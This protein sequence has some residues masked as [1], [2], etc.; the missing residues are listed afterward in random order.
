MIMPFGQE[1]VDTVYKRCVKPICDELDLE[2]RHAGELFGTTPIYN[3]ILREIQDATIIV[4]DIS[5][6]NPNVFYELGIAHTIKQDRTIIITND[7][8]ESAPFDVQHFR[9][10]GYEDTITGGDE[11]KESL[12]KTIIGLLEDILTQKS[13]EFA[14]VFQVCD[15]FG[16]LGNLM[17]LFAIK[18]AGVKVSTHDRIFV[19]YRQPNLGEGQSVGVLSSQRLRLF[20]ELGYISIAEDII[21]LTEIGKTFI[22]YLEGLGLVVREVKVNPEP[23]EGFLSFLQS[24]LDKDKADTKDT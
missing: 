14:L 21:T 11:F 5:G 8:F 23:A 3:D 13:D 22:T 15:S 12:N 6:R 10:I 1:V 4:A 24:S 16:N 19:T 20:N 9:I 2:I 7:G 17:S 18:Y